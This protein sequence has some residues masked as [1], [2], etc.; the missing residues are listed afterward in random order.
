MNANFTLSQS[1]LVGDIVLSSY[2]IEV[3]YSMILESG[4]IMLR[5]GLEVKPTKCAVFHDRRS[6]NNWYK[7]RNDNLPE[8]RIQE[9]NIQLCRRD[10]NYKY[11]I[12]RCQLQIAIPLWGR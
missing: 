10:A 8:A 3:I 9:N 11:P 2:N 1:K 12:T 7:G 6:G 4:P 5:A